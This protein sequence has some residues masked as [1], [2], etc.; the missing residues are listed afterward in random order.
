M[1]SKWN[2]EQEREAEARRR[3]VLVGELAEY[4]QDPRHLSDRAQCTR[5]P[6]HVLAMWH[7]AASKGGLEALSPKDWTDLPLETALVIEER[8]AQLGEL[9][10][11]EVITDE[12]IEGLRHRHG[13]SSRKAARWLQRYRVGGRWALAPDQ[14]PESLRRRQRGKRAPRA[15]GTLNEAAL[16]E[17]N[18]RR[19]LLGH[20]AD[21]A[22]VSEQ[23]VEEH[24][25]QVSVSPRTLWTYRR[26]YRLY[27][28]AGLAPQQ[29]S[30]LKLRYRIS[31][32]MVK[33]IIGIRLSQPDLPIHEV[34]ARACEK[35]RWLGEAEPSEGQV[36]AICDTI[37]K[38]HTQLADGREDDFKSS[39]R[40]TYRLRFGK[41]VIILQIDHTQT[42]I[43]AKDL[44]HPKYRA[45]S[46]EVR[47]WLTTA[48][49]ANAR[50]LPARI[51]SYDRPDRFTVAAV[52]RDAII[53]TDSKPY[54]GIV[55]EIWVDRGKELVSRHV[56]LLTQELGILLQ[57]LAPHQPQLKG[58]VERFF[59]TLNTRLWSTLPGYV[60]SNTAERNPTVKAELSIAQIAEKFDAFVEQYHNQVHEELG[61]TP[62]QYWMEHC[63]TLPADPRQLDI[64]LLEPATR[65]VLKEGI[66]YEG[67]VYWHQ[68]LALLVGQDVVVRAEPHYAAPEEIEVF[69][70]GQWVCTAFATDS[71]RGYAVGRQEVGD[72]QRAQ[73]KAANRAIEE[74][75]SA[76]GDANHEIAEKQANIEDE[77][78]QDV[79]EERAVF[80]AVMP[81]KNGRQPKKPAEQSRPAA[82]DED[83]DLFDMLVDA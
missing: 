73:R 56:Q 59:G 25:K 61:M 2:L 44:R 3:L 13:W 69:A 6:R 8:F 10:I 50:L 64:L 19:Q 39:S 70:E 78:P 20:L 68:E 45:K 23:E 62:L 16:E 30:D 37:P 54:C 65:R 15:L 60:G 1:T 55:D 4:E 75:R 31:E 51:F 26:Q 48:I 38:P 76:V 34:H 18:K 11:A 53:V 47:P 77:G 29:R 17:I 52:I 67:R 72:A 28:L 7:R 80:E 21:Q 33:L 27:G 63:H 81:P 71:A 82:D 57:P 43:L 32:R 41:E 66:K 40:I 58:I 74:A 14:D 9:A 42:D 83:D 24:A 35:A 49:V 36:R 22:R 46:G 12:Q 5:V 79:S